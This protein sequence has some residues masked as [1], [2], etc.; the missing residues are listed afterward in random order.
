MKNIMKKIAASLASILILSSAL[1]GVFGVSQGSTG[2]SIG[3][4]LGASV[5]IGGSVSVSRNLNSLKLYPGGMPFGVKFFTEGVLVVGFCDINN[6]AGTVNP[7][8]SAGIRLKDVITAV[9][10]KTLG[11]ASELTSIIEKSGG[12]AVS[13]TYTRDKNEYTVAVTPIYSEADGR[14]KTGVWVRDSGAGIG[15]VTFIMPADNSFAGLGHGIC[16]GDTGELV[17]MD[18]GVVTSVT[19]SGL[20]RGIPGDPGEIK[21]YFGPGKCGSLVGNT[22]FGVYGV[23]SEPPAPSPEGPLPAASRY[24]V[25]EGAAYIWCTL[26]TNEIKKYSIEISAVNT[27]SEGNKCFTVTITDPALLEKTGGI[28]QGM[29]GSPIIQNGRIIGAVTH[30]LINDPSRGYGIFVE[31]MLKNMPEILR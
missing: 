3:E 20:T 29:S 7:A 16:D 23:F 9:N 21:G 1:T 2:G 10:G 22:D 13:I 19:I 4:T 11:S 18:R 8:Y 6:G 12:E 24:Q 25:K 14:Y 26:D 27:G 17:P 28:I 15:T 5:Y 30:V 31:N